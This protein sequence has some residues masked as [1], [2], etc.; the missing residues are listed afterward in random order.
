MIK[1]IF[2]PPRIGKT[3]FLTYLL[4]LAVFDKERNYLMQKALKEK[5]VNGFDLMIPEHCVSANY[6]ITFRDYGRTPRKARLINPFKLG[7]ANDEV[8]THF[9]LPYETIGI[10]EA[11]RVFNSRNF[12]NFRDWQ[13]EFYEQHGHN[14]INIYL[15][16]QRPHLIDVNIRDLCGFIEIISLDVKEDKNGFIERITW[17]VREIENSG[18]LDTYLASG[19]RDKSC[20]I[21]YMVSTNVNVFDMY[22]SRNCE[23][24][25]YDGHFNSDFDLQYSVNAG[26]TKE[27]YKKYLNDFDFKKPK[28]LEGK[29]K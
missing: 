26:K 13:S 14:N 24:K 18:L 28:V 6:N 9:N 12:K 17:K 3:A 2:G 11:Q 1:I 27:D 4:W 22:E 29:A 15:D 16:C 5:N 25:F 23:P 20:Y 19:R 7:F 21:E 10:A 8:G